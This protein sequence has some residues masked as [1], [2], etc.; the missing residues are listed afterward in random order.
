M[1]QRIQNSI[2]EYL[3]IR[4][5]GT[6]LNEVQHHLSRVAAYLSNLSLKDDRVL[7]CLTVLSD[8]QETSYARSTVFGAEVFLSPGEET[9]LEVPMTQRALGRLTYFISGHPNLVITTFEVGNVLCQSNHC[10][11]KFGQCN[12]AVEV[13]N[14]VRVRVAYRNA[15]QL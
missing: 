13:G 11:V 10:G 12:E 6:S 2:R 7:A 8:L 15:G 3:G 5:L 9:T 14:R 4:F 1:R